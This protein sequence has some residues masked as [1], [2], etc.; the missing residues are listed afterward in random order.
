[1]DAV[2]DNPHTEVSPELVVPTLNAIAA[3]LETKRA[4]I[5][6]VERKTFKYGYLPRQQLDVYY[7]PSSSGK[8]PVLFFFYGGGFVSGERI[9]PAPWSLIYAG[10]GSFYAKRGF[11]TVIPDYRLVPEVSYPEPAEDVGDAVL[12]VVRNSGIVAAAGSVEPDVSALFL[13]G[14]SAGAVH[15]A[16]LL[17]E[18][19][20]RASI[21]KPLLPR[22]RGLV[23]SGGAYAYE[24]GKGYEF[25][26]HYYGTVQAA[27]KNEPLALLKAAPAEYVRSLPDILLVQAERDTVWANSSGDIFKDA[28]SARLGEEVPRL[29]CKGH[30]HVSVNPA[31]GSGEGEEWAEDVVLWMK[32]RL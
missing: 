17:L 30:N 18:P 2:A 19:W 28:L 12:W 13:L 27:S 3:V 11:L 16:T 21:A 26:I 4:E 25:F 15:L 8:A 1:M 32:E 20:L 5:E 9:F 22:I 23:L 31:L 7:P 29:I 24:P 14:H 6:A 10:L